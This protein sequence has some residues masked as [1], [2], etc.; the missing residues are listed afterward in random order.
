M[1]PAEETTF[2]SASQALTD[3]SNDDDKAIV[4]DGHLTADP[5]FRFI[6]LAWSR[7]ALMIYF[8]IFLF[9]FVEGNHISHTSQEKNQFLSGIAQITSK[10]PS[11]SVSLGKNFTLLNPTRPV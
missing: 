10:L 6:C 3:D 7:I 9:L 1:E 2:R 5:L 4:V 8:S 11:H